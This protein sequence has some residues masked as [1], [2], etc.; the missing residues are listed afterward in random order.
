MHDEAIGT[1]ATTRIDLNRCGTPLLE[2]VSH[3]DL[4]SASEAK[5]Y[6]DELKLRM[7][8]LGV[9]DCEM[10]EGSLRVDAN[11][12]LHIEVDGKKW[13]RRLLKSRT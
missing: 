10:Q 12:N 7:T 2:I 8:H 11:V 1:R 4:R 6:L 9:S 3:P 5:E 13:Q